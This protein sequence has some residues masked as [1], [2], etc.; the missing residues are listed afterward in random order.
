MGKSA[1]YSLIVLTVLLNHEIIQAQFT[2][3][4]WNNSTLDEY[5]FDCAYN[6]STGNF[7]L[8]VVRENPEIPPYPPSVSAFYNYHHILYLTDSAFTPVDSIYLDGDGH[9]K[10][11]IKTIL[12]ADPDL[13]IVSVYALDT[14]TGLKDACIIWLNGELEIVQE[15]YYGEPDISEEL[16]A[17]S[18]N[19][20]GNIVMNQ[21]Y[22]LAKGGVGIFR[23]IDMQGNII[24]ES[25]DTSIY[26]LL[27]YIYDFPEIQKYVFVQQE[28][29]FLMDYLFNLD[30]VIGLNDSIYNNVTSLLLSNHEILFSSEYMEYSTYPPPYWDIGLFK[31]NILE[32]IYDTIF[33]GVPDTNDRI[34]QTCENSDGAIYVT[35]SKNIN[36]PPTDTWVSLY[37]VDQNLNG[38]QWS[39]NYGGKGEYMPTIIMVLSDDNIVIMGSFWDF[40]NFPGELYQ[41]DIFILKFD[42]DSITTGQRDDY[43]QENARLYPN[44]FNHWVNIEIPQSG[45][46]KLESI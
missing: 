41:K 6:E 9:Y 46:R 30:T 33:I 14:L 32:G 36:V 44:P 40:Y 13:I 1:I 3:I 17:I 23:E 16:Y 37:K 5:L 12:K 20:N 19:H 38:V 29:L 42:P 35:C 27:N 25:T 2:C 21:G 4:E 15:R 34:A 11:F 7:L 22:L 43:I 10:F 26:W 39:A 28:K 45:I 8:N 24:N 31:T 18:I